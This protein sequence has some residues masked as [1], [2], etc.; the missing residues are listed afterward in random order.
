MSLLSAK[1]YNLLIT[2]TAKIQPT[3]KTLMIQEVIKFNLKKQY[4]ITKNYIQTIKNNK[5]CL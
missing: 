3:I 5:K 1:I 2:N 4:L